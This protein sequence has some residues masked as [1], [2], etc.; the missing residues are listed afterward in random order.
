MGKKSGSGSYMNNQDHISES[1]EKIIW[2]TYLNSL[3]QIR[4]GPNLDPGWKKWDPGSG[5][6]N[7]VWDKSEG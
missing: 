4:D 5:I 6:C 3:M 7:T 1:F 2:F